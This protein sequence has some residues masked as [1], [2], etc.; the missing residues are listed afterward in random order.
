MARNLLAQ[1][2]GRDDRPAEAAGTP[3][4]AEG[5]G[6]R[7]MR[8]DHRETADD[9]V[10]ELFRSDRYRVAEYRDGLQWLLQRKR[11]RISPRGAAWDT[12]A[13]C[14]TRKALA[15]LHRSLTG[16]DAPEI[17]DLPE[18]FKRRAGQ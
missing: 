7:H 13:Y 16:V 12:L 4:I 8:A 9:Y 2:P 17:G 1:E 18:R 6:E 5:N 14:V 3:N 15:R 11:P 10:F